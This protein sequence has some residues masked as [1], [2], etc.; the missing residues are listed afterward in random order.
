MNKENRLTWLR[1]HHTEK[2]NGSSRTYDLY[3]CTCGN[4]KIARRDG[5]KGGVTRSCGCLKAE[6]ARENLENGGRRMNWGNINGGGAKKGAPGQNANKGKIAIYEN[7]N[8]KGKSKR[9]YV[10]KDELN[11]IF[12]GITPAFP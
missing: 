12:A 8:D 9:R 7:Q 4:T 10:T 2:K 11:D 5:V 1:F 6:K 3:Q